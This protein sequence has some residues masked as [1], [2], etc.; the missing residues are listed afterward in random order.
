[1]N[2]PPRRCACRSSWAGWPG[3]ACRRRRPT[4]SPPPAA[5]PTPWPA[6][7]P[8]SACC[9]SPTRP[10][11]RC[12]PGAGPS[13]ATSR[14]SRWTSTPPGPRPGGSGAPSTTSSS[15]AWPAGRPPITG[16]T[17]STWTSC[18]RRSRSAPGGTTRR[19][20]TPSSPPASCSP[21]ASAIPPPGS[22]RS[23]NGWPSSRHRRRPAWSPPSPGRWRRC[24]PPWSSAWPGPRSARWTSPPRTCG[25]SPP[26]S[27]SPGPGSSATT[28][29]VRP[30]ARRSTRPSCPRARGW[31]S[32]SPRTRPRCPT[33][34]CSEAV[35]RP[36][37]DSLIASSP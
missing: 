6:S 34:T 17:A 31:T 15:P 19:P 29:W 5:R 36:A 33:R 1:M 30:G 8:P 37:M 11:H 2:G 28:R 14:C 26:I 4:R 12:G 18:G 10:T 35:W 7:R 27:T 21:P 23:T 16:P 24:R 13:A 9:S 20:A 32:G 22:G 25:A 3:R